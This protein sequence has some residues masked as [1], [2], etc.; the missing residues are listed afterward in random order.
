NLHVRDGLSATT[1]RW[2]LTAT[3]QSNWH[4]L[5]W[6]SHALDCS[7]FGLNASGHHAVSLLFHIINVLLLFW[8][9]QRVTNAIG[10]SVA[11]A[12][13]FALHPL[14]VESVAWIA[15]RKNLLCTM[16]FLLALAAYGW[17]AER[18]NWKR[19]AAVAALIAC[20]LAAKPMAITLPFVLLL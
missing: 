1:L 9:L 6:I 5:T 8:V 12:A 4:P 18:P 2:A 10:S 15:E 11:V 3:E 17:Y 13:L 7:L 20:A 16:F 19:Y 14:N